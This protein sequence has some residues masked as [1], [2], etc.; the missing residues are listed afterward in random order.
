[1]CLLAREI[2][3]AL[4]LGK[5]AATLAMAHE[6]TGD[7]AWARFLIGRAYWA[8]E[9]KD[10]DEAERELNIALRL[11]AT[12]E[13]RPL[14]AFCNT[15]LCGIYAT[16]GDQAKAQEF[17]AAATATY[18]ELGMHPLSLEPGG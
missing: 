8:S 3:T 2:E 9:P 17:D 15:T 16:R 5:E 12:S 10:L 14:A 11:A 18:R 7:E 6:A 1:V 13:A 4:T